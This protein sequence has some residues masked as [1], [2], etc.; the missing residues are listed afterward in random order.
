MDNFKEEFPGTKVY[1][2]LNTAATGLL[3]ERVLEFRQEHAMDLLVAGDHLP[4][5]GKITTQTREAVARFFNASPNQVALIPNFSLGFNLL[6]EGVNPT[7]KILLVK[8]DYPSVEWAVESRGFTTVYVAAGANMEEQI[9]EIVERQRPDIFIFSLVQWISGIKIEESFLRKL[10]ED[11]PDLVLIADGTQ[12]CGM[13]EFD[14]KASALDVLGTSTYKWL[15]AGFGSAFFLFKEDNLKSISP[16][17]TGYGSRMGAYKEEK[18]TFI[19]KFEPGHLDGLSFGSLLVALELLTEIG[20]DRVE[21]HVRQLALQAKEAFTA[22]ELL[23]P[24]ISD[25]KTHSSI[26]N[27]KGDDSLF[28]QLRS[29]GIL[30]AQRGT[31]IR[32]SFHYY[33]DSQDLD[34]LMKAISK[35]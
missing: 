8:D 35:T 11:F 21:R 24:E 25:R 16:K 34:R 12:Y 18:D 17:S 31:G 3:S 23:S 33:N 28:N 4:L 14:F 10:K 7:A 1:T 6:M 19:G 30:C 32:V 27:I 9:V 15:N 5:Q 22:A 29:Q 13:E 20:M 26:F 2:Y